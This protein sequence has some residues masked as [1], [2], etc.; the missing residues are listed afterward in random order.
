MIDTYGKSH[1]LPGTL[2]TLLS[3]LSI[4]IWWNPA[5]IASMPFVLIFFFGMIMPMVLNP[6]TLPIRGVSKEAFERLWWEDAGKLKN[7]IVNTF[8]D[9]LKSK[10]YRK[11]FLDTPVAITTGAVWFGITAPVK[12][13]VWAGRKIKGLFKRSDNAEVIPDQPAPV[14][15]PATA[16]V[17]EVAAVADQPAIHEQLENAQKSLA[18]AQR[19]RHWQQRSWKAGETLQEYYQQRMSRLKRDQQ[20]AREAIEAAAQAV[21]VSATQEKTTDPSRLGGIDMGS[22]H[23]TINIR[24]DD[25]GMPLPARLQDPVMIN[26]EGLSPVIRSIKPLRSA[27]IPL[28]SELMN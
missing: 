9:G 4:G 23:L 22:D 21:K 27:Q 6:G 19:V 1:I 15:Q 2:G 8:M 12:A 24:V 25:N 26:I 14:A 16:L 3:A 7:K 13:V 5:L 17:Q 28:F 10:N 18:R 20:K 11:A